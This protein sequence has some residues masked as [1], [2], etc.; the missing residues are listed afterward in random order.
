MDSVRFEGDPAPVLSMPAVVPAAVPASGKDK[1]G[2]GK[3]RKRGDAGGEENEG[4]EGG[5]DPEERELPGVWDRVVHRSGGTAVVVF[6]D[7]ASME[8]A[9]RAVQKLAGGKAAGKKDGR[10]VTWGEK[11]SG[12]VPEMGMSRKS[13]VHTFYPLYSTSFS[14]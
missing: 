5:N 13:K 3:K 12:D 7:R 9:V 8:M 6:V 14:G 4:G 2:S 11:V 10:G 1:A